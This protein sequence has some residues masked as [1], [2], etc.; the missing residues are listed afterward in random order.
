MCCLDNKSS[1]TNRSKGSPYIYDSENVKL[2][3]QSMP[4][5]GPLY[6]GIGFLF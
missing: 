2:G 1:K 5:K 3:H 4:T 6:K